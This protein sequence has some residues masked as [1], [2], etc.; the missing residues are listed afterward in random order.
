[1]VARIPPQRWPVVFPT[2]R[3][4]DLERGSQQV[5][6]YVPEFRALCKQAKRGY[7]TDHQAACRFWILLGDVVAYLAEENPEAARRLMVRLRSE[8]HTSELQS[9]FDLVCRLLLD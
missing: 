8:E 7:Q 3:S 9:R 1:I 4:S 6:A 5:F 2:R